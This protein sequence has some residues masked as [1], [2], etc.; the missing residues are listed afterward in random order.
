VTEAVIGAIAR[1]AVG[2]FGGVLKD[3]PATELGAHAIKAAL[4]RASI[5]PEQVEDVL[6][7]NVIS[8]ALGQGP[9][10][11]AAIAAGI[12]VTTPAATINMLC[13]SGLRAITMAAESILCG[14][15]QVTVAGGMESMSRAPFADTDTRW[16]SRMGHYELIDCMLRD[17]LQDGFTGEH[18]GA[19]M[20]RLAQQR[21]ISRQAQDEY[22]AE[23]QHRCEVAQK[24]G[25]FEPEITP[26]EIPQRKGDPIVIDTDEHPRSGTT[27]EILAKLKPVF[28]EDGTITAGNA[29]GLNDGAAAA[30][31]VSADVAAGMNLDNPV[32]MVAWAESARAPDEFGIAPARAIELALTDAGMTL[33]DIELIEANEAFAAQTLALTQEVGWDLEKVNVNGGAIALGHPIGASGA[34]V[35]AT[36]LYEMQRQDVTVGMATLCCGG[37]IGVCT[38]VERI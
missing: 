14:R 26:L 15:R 18:M 24:E 20:D 22:A 25:R 33:D 28:V 5:A 34:R 29:S 4:E 32:R 3:V 11:Q 16:G 1:T 30:V 37:G 6:M 7:G 12:P 35:L 19:A 9:A 10:R 2:T 38:I 31:V 13:G 36:L 27:V 8:A 17:G 23:S 21:G